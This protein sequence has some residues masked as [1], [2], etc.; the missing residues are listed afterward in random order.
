MKKTRTP[1]LSLPM[2][3]IRVLSTDVLVHA[4][5]GTSQ[6]ETGSLDTRST[7]KTCISQLP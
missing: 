3:S 4:A 5:G 6:R 1:K 7:I 2:Q